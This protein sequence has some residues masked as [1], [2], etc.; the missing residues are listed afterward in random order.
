MKSVGFTVQCLSATPHTVSFTYQEN[1]LGAFC[2]CAA[3]SSGTACK[4]RLSILAG[5]DAGIV[6]G[7]LDQI[8]K[9]LSGRKVLKFEIEVRLFKL[10]AAKADLE[11]NEAAGFQ[12]K[13]KI[14]ISMLK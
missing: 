14:I 10:K 2:T 3:G 7:S 6:S 5:S 1:K 9:V 12:S 4:H 11:K 8:P 13:K